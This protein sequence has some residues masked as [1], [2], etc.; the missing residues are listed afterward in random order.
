M[1]ETRHTWVQSLRQEDALEEEIATTPVFL[2]GKSYSCLGGYSSWG[3]KELDT[4]EQAHACLTNWGNPLRASFSQV[5]EG[6]PRK[7]KK[8]FAA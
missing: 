1:Q 3:H 8:P 6:H 2:P 5:R 4:A 7:G